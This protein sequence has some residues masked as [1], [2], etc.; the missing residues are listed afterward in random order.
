MFLL[1]GCSNTANVTAQ[2]SS[3]DSASAISYAISLFE[4][5]YK[6]GA[7]EDNIRAYEG[8]QK[9]WLRFVEIDDSESLEWAQKCKTTV[10]NDPAL[11]SNELAYRILDNKK[12]MLSY[13]DFKDF[14]K[15]NGIVVIADGTKDGYYDDLNNRADCLEEDYWYDPLDK[16]RHSKGEVGFQHVEAYYLFAGD[17]AVKITERVFYGT[18]KKDYGNSV[19]AVLY[20]QGKLIR[21]DDYQSINT[22]MNKMTSETYMLPADRDYALF[23]FIGEDLLILHH[24]LLTISK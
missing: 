3:T 13:E 11:L 17:L 22:F 6:D 14:V 8:I 10:L 21:N 9:A 1:G 4:D 5:S 24:N 20:C 15:T 19:S 7:Y 16:S 12:A 2:D 18:S 23:S